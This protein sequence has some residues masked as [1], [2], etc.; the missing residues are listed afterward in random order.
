MAAVLEFEK[1]IL[2]IQEKI[3]ELKKMSQESGM[4]LSIDIS[5]LE[6]VSP[7]TRKIV[8]S[9]I[10]QNNNKEKNIPTNTN[11]EFKTRD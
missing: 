3:E 10:A 11:S 1:P 8:E 6:K 9:A 4:D 2:E 5:M 7:E